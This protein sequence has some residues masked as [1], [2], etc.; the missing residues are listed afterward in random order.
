MNNPIYPVYDKSLSKSGPSKVG[1][2]EACPCGIGLK[3]KKCHGNAALQNAVRKRKEI[4]AKARRIRAEV[5]QIFDDSAHW[6]EC[7]RKPDEERIDPDPDGKM[8]GIGI[9]MDV[10]LMKAGVKL[11]VTCPVCGSDNLERI[12]GRY[13]GCLDCR[14]GPLEE[15]G[16]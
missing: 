6:N 14:K 9:A 8:F 5:E 7:V 12:G 1:R 13:T 4:I 3:F 10:V 2:N 15:G 11:A 16:Q